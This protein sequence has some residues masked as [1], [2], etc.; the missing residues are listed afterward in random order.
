VLR[1]VP[2]ACLVLLGLILL[3]NIVGRTF[4]PFSLTWFDEVVT[5]IFAWMV[6]I[7]AA[8]LWREHSHFALDLVPDLVRGTRWH[9]VLLLAFAV[10]GLVFAGALTWYGWIFFG[11][12]TATTPVL[13]W[14]Q[15][16][17]YL[18]VPLGGAVMTVYAVRDLVMALGETLRPPPAAGRG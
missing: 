10:I 8:A 17:A 7:G 5:M 9:G 11:R 15:A 12:T 3:F 6:F 1:L 18:C 2:I 4:G 13:G 16:W 14:P